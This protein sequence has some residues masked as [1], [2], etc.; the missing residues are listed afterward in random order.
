MKHTMPQRSVFLP[1]AIEKLR[2]Y[3]ADDAVE[4]ERL[5]P[6][7]K[8]YD[9]MEWKQFYTLCQTALNTYCACHWAIDELNDYATAI[10]PTH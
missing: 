3:A 5:G 4:A 8:A 1:R 6:L 10:F 2:E 9:A 7:L